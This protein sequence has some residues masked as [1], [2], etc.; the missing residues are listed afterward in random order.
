[1]TIRREE[2]WKNK[3]AKAKPHIVDERRNDLT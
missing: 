1:M 3:K 2:I